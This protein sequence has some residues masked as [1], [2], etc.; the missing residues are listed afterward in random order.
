MPAGVLGTAFQPGRPEDQ[1]TNGTGVRP[2]PVQ[3]AIQILSL[4]LPR[5]LGAAAPLDRS[6]L[7]APRAPHVNAIVESILQRVLSGQTGG[8]AP[9]TAGAV[10][11]RTGSV[12][13]EL[14]Q[15]LGS[16]P[17][18]SPG[19]PRIGIEQPAPS[20]VRDVRARP[21]PVG[22]TVPPNRGLSRTFEDP[23][24]RTSLSGF[25]PLV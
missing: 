20:P 7:V 11:R 19:A 21:M 1:Q 17:I 16:L 14:G 25:T 13:D 5:V 3:Q 22:P 4:R 12:S 6:L 8:G 18:G 10:R 23:G 15:L 9:E 24:L 2:S